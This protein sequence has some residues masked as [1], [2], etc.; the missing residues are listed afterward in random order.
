[1]KI[2]IA[3][4]NIYPFSVGGHEIMLYHLAKNLA[5]ENEVH[6][7]IKGKEEDYPKKMENFWI[8]PL[9]VPSINSVFDRTI[10]MIL[11]ALKTTKELPKYDLDVVDLSS[12]YFPFRMGKTK[13]IATT[14]PLIESLNYLSNFK[15][16]TNLPFIL[17]RTLLSFIKVTFAD[18]VI[19][20]DEMAVEETKKFLLAPS[21]KIALTKNGF[22]PKIFNT[23]KSRRNVRKIHGIKKDDLVLLF[24]GKI[25]RDKGVLDILNSMEYLDL[26][27]TKVIMVGDGSEA[28]KIKK[29]YKDNVI[30]T[31]HI[32]YDEVAEYYAAAD[33]LLLPSHWEIRPLV[34]LE[35]MACGTPVIASTVGG[36]PYMIKNGYNGLLVPPRQPK[37]LAE[38]ILQ[39]KNDENLKKKL[40][41][42]GLEFA[43]EN[44]MDK[45]C[46]RTMDVYNEVMSRDA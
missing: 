46:Q 16:I 34:I 44:T 35:A 14:G 19:C 32:K 2:G 30:V 45:F 8:H 28:K 5:K 11:F 15:K 41:K 31:G 7:F 6:V 9:N 10:G 33:V 3:Y 38:K 22:D 24:V 37:M 13:M 40:I 18:K 21:N 20:T 39:I 4:Y 42:N 29:E 27:N 12:E 23:K 25:T 17:L 1:M 36:I 43:K 26:P